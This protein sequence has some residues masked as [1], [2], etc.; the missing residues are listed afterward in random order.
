MTI[1]TNFG[2]QNSTI[3]MLKGYIAYYSIFMYET[4]YQKSLRY[5]LN[6][7][8]FFIKFHSSF[9]YEFKERSLTGFLLFQKSWQVDHI[10][11]KNTIQ[12]F[13]DTLEEKIL[14]MCRDYNNILKCLF[15]N[16][17]HTCIYILEFVLCIE[18]YLRFN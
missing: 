2:Q 13:N 18:F 5:F 1:I 8:M 14:S 10:H 17:F 16:E 6:S 15:K 7:R 3:D 12:N 9:T 4:I 11:M